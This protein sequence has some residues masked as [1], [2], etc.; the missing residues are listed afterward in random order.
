MHLA[1]YNQL[2]KE[3]QDTKVPQVEAGLVNIG[4]T[5]SAQ[6]TTAHT[7][8]HCSSFLSGL[9]LS[10]KAEMLSK[11]KHFLLLFLKKIQ[12]V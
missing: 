5:C 9:C 7:D 8:R 10:L 3:N 6:L 1:K 2:Y 11:V 12:D 4:E